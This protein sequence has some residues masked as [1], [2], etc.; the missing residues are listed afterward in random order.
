[1]L[2]RSNGTIQRIGLV[3]KLTGGLLCAKAAPIAAMTETIAALLYHMHLFIGLSWGAIG[4][5]PTFERPQYK[6][7]RHEAVNPQRPNSLQTPIW[8]KRIFPAR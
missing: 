4:V 8:P 3:G 6:A 5:S 7:Q 2:F 1:M